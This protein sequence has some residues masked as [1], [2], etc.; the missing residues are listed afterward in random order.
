[1]KKKIDLQ[2]SNLKN[3]FPDT[4]S[5]RDSRNYSLFSSYYPIKDQLT[6]RMTYQKEV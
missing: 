6:L 3:N 1:M 4:N 2:L 5:M